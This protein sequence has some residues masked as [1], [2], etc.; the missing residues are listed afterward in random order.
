[1]NPDLYALVTD[2]KGEGNRI[3]MG[4]DRDPGKG[5]GTKGNTELDPEIFEYTDHQDL[6]KPGPEVEQVNPDLRTRYDNGEL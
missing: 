2:K 5:R 6:L 1:M 3:G 4:R